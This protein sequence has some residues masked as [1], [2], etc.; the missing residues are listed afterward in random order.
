M[1]AS[2]VWNRTSG[3]AFRS[4]FARSGH[5]DLKHYNAAFCERGNG[6]PLILIPGLAGGY[7]L[8]GPLAQELAQHFR[9]ISY[10]LRGESD[11]FAL[12]RRFGLRDLVEDLH[13]FIDWCG[14]E[15]PLLCGVSFGGLLALEY[16]ATYPNASPGVAVQG[17]G[18]QFERGLMQRIAS[19]VLSGYPLPNN[20]PFVNQFFNLLFGGQ[21]PRALFEFVTHQ[22]WQTD[23]SVMAHRLR[24]VERRDLAALVGRIAAPTCIIAGD[25]DLLVSRES[26]RRLGAAI[27]NARA[28]TIDG[29]G[30]LAFITHPKQIA[31]RFRAFLA[32]AADDAPFHQFPR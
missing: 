15:R 20:S 13:E 32:S 9:V 11:C 10:Q 17:V 2:H 6:Q 19:L 31:A 27:P 22:C 8:L 16:A 1:I 29:C 24:L 18:A 3:A 30:H 7:E 21:Q 12:R 4:A 5:A 26:L 28:E 14:L 23:Q 25:R